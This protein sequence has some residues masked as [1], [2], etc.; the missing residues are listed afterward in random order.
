MTSHLAHS[1][2]R[3]MLFPNMNDAVEEG[4]VGK[5]DGLAFNLPSHLGFHTFDLVAFDEQP[6]HRVLPEV[7]V[8]G[9]F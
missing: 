6:C 2:A 3:K 8:G 4:A 7:E 9:L 5:D 1:S